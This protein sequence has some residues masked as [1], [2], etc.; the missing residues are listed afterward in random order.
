[1]GFSEYVEDFILGGYTYKLCR[2]LYATCI[3]FTISSLH[4]N[5]IVIAIGSCLTVSDGNC[6]KRLLKVMVI[7]LAVRKKMQKV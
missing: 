3:L 5:T 4:L 1:M 7:T 2:E 6:R